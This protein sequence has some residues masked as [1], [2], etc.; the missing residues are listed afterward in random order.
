MRLRRLLALVAT[1]VVLLGMPDLAVATTG[2]W[3]NP[4]DDPRVWAKRTSTIST[5]LWRSGQANYGWHATVATDPK[6]NFR[7]IREADLRAMFGSKVC[8]TP[9]VAQGLPSLNAEMRKAKIITPARQAA[10]LATI[11]YESCF[12]YALNEMGASAYYRGRGYVQLTAPYNYSAAGRYLG[13]DL[14]NRA[15]LAG[16]LQYSAPIARW[17]WTVHRPH[18]NAAADAFDMGL[19]SRYIGYAPSG[20][21]DSQ[22]CAAFKSAYQYLS[23]KPAPRTTVCYRH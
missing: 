5:R 9:R 4:Q 1:V 19:V 20:Y 3:S 11:A 13:V 15:E 18:S 2:G 12:D 7:E 6:N 14:V 8:N 22:R 17:Y 21:A 16:S 23:G 10:F